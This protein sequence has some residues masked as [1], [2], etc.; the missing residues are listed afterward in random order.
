MT[1]VMTIGDVAKVAAGFAFSPSLQGKTNRRYPFV[2]VSDFALA[3][4]A[5]ITSA[6]N[7]V[8]DDDL[9]LLKAKTYRP[10]T[11]VFPKVG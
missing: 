1:K 8:D 7:T 6:A 9:R 3:N 10:E 4:D 11:V 5:V 2:K